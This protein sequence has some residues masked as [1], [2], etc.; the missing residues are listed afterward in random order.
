MRRFQQAEGI[1]PDGLVGPRT[2]APL[3]RV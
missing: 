3:L 1:D 2:W